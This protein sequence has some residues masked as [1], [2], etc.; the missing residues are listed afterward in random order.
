MYG[1]WA[2]LRATPENQLSDELIRW[3]ADAGCRGGGQACEFVPASDSRHKAGRQLS[4]GLQIWAG[5]WLWAVTCDYVAMISDYVA[6]TWDYVAMAV[7]VGMTAVIGSAWSSRTLTMG[8]TLWLS[9]YGCGCGH[10]S[11]HQ[12]YRIGP[13]YGL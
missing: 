12:A 13:G 4:S 7:A 6:V 11:C 8:C 5:R 1:W 9:S 2:G 10:G 3:G